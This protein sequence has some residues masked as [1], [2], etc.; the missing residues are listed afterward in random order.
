MYAEP[1]M[2]TIS[3]ASINVCSCA[4]VEQPSSFRHSQSSVQGLEKTIGDAVT[5]HVTVGQA[6]SVNQLKVMSATPTKLRLLQVE[7]A[8][9]M[10]FNIS[11]HTTRGKKTT[12][13]VFEQNLTIEFLSWGQYMSVHIMG[14]VAEAIN[15]IIVV[16]VAH[17]Q[18]KTALIVHHLY[19]MQGGGLAIH[20]PMHAKGVIHLHFL[21]S[22]NELDSDVF[23]WGAG[24]AAHFELLCEPVNG[25]SK[26]K[27]DTFTPRRGPQ[28]QKRGA[29]GSPEVYF[30]VSAK[31]LPR[32]HISGHLK[33]LR[34]ISGNTL[35]TY[36]VL[37][38]QCYYHRETRLNAT[39][40]FC[41]CSL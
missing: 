16:W 19:S 15:H 33:I 9:G 27:A 29:K 23:K 20:A 1:G 4:R 21:N 35:P 32:W 39:K 41:I 8:A 36:Q 24:N 31:I 2:F 7:R 30:E 40:R 25:W 37:L 6:T 10:G 28:N 18:D 22:A 3:F 13:A 12:L 5:K 26:G 38:S 17:P 34:T 11:N 14:A